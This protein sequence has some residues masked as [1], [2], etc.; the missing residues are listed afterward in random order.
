MRPRTP[1]GRPSKLSASAAKTKWFFR[2]GRP[3]SAV[4]RNCSQ[5]GGFM[6]K[7]K[8]AESGP[9]MP[10]RRT[11]EEGCAQR[12]ESDPN[13]RMWVQVAKIQERWPGGK[14]LT[15]DEYDA[16]IA[17]AKAAPIGR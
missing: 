12:A 7:D 5:S 16:A 3:S 10:E 1:T 13:A 9:A 2:A 15:A 8:K 6:S 17:R 11:V 14:T 4:P